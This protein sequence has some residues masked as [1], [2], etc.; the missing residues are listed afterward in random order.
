[1]SLKGFFA[2][3][4]V[5]CPWKIS[6]GCPLTDFSNI[7]EFV[8]ESGQLRFVTRHKNHVPIKFVQYTAFEFHE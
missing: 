8:V 4:L 3:L 2:N 1:M 5:G 7:V 6:R